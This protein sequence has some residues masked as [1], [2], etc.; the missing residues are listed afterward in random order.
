MSRVLGLLLLIAATASFGVMRSLELKR[1]P[2]ELQSMIEALTILK[3]DIHSRTLPL[4][5]A[6][7]HVAGMSDRDCRAFFLSVSDHLATTKQSFS[8]LWRDELSALDHLSREELDTLSDLGV[9]LGRYDA[10]A[11]ADAIDACIR[12][13]TQHRLRSLEQA[14]QY[15]KLY[16]GLGLT[17]G[18]M[19]A[20]IL[21]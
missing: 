4:P 21:Y 13:L 3:H 2:R 5:D 6:L 18:A 14:R 7:A 17:L 11:Q 10:S 8:E 20:V 9:H 12:M 1:K 15:G 19:L 16:T